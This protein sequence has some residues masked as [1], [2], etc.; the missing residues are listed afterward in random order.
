M[1]SQGEA[2][3]DVL[4]QDGNDLVPLTHIDNW[5]S[6]VKKMMQNRSMVGENISKYAED[7]FIC[8]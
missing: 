6:S 8:C 5:S 7:F 3:H 1:N 2:L 4:N